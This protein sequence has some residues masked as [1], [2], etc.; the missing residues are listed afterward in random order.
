MDR[1]EELLNIIEH[2]PALIP[3]V[4]EMVYLECELEKLRKL[5]KIRVHPDD[6]MKQK[7]TPASKQYKEFLQQY[8][9]I[10][11]TIV[12]ATHSDEEEQ[13]SPLRKWLNEHLDQ[14]E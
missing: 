7:L 13:E 12:R 5:P 1:K 8:V 4:D 11:R 2:D 6:P 14:T 9:N 3:L 10:V